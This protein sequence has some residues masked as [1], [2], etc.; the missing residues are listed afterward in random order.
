MTRT[1]KLVHLKRYLV[2]QT[3]TSATKH[4]TTNYGRTSKQLVYNFGILD[5]TFMGWRFTESYRSNTT[6]AL[7]REHIRKP[8]LMEKYYTEILQEILYS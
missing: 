6:Q 5:L 3:R 4:T 8:R 1:W 2:N 7:G